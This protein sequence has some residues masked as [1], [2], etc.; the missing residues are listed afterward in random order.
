MSFGRQLE[1]RTCHSPVKSNPVTEVSCHEKKIRSLASKNLLGEAER[2]LLR[3]VC[4]LTG[5]RSGNLQIQSDGCLEGQRGF[6]RDGHPVQEVPGQVD[7]DLVTDIH[8]H[9]AKKIDCVAHIE[10]AFLSFL[11][12]F[13]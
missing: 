6:E 8:G 12:L 3:A 13:F 2:T 4:A 7:S 11:F 5:N 1:Y 9:M 10:M